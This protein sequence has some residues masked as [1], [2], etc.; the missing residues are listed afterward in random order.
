MR[1]IRIAMLALAAAGLL[2]GCD[3]GDAA[4]PARNHSAASS[5]PVT[6]PRVPAPLLDGKP[7]WADN[8]AHTAEENVA[9]QFEHWGAGFGAKD[10]K[11]YARKA[12]AFIDHAGK[13]V[14]KVS[15]P[16]GDTLLYEKASNTFAI[17]R[18]DGAPRLFRKPVGGAADWEAAKNDAGKSGYSRK[19][20]NAPEARDYGRRSGG[21]D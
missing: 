4:A 12:R 11:D 1:A 18:R 5:A 2:W 19:R 8:R 17:V 9:Y 21:D 20:Y 15:R 6:R 10:A 3:R 13:G 16:N 14:E 7:M